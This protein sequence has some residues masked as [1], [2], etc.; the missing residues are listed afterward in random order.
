[1]TYIDS[2][3]SIVIFGGYAVP[4]Y[5]LGSLLMVFAAARWG[6]FP[7]GGFTSFDFDEM[8]AWEQFVDLLHHA[9][10]PLVCY[11][12]GSFA[13]VTLLM[14]NHLLE[15]LAADYVRTAVAKGV[16][17]KGAVFKHALRNSLIPLATNFGQSFTIFV[18][19][20]FLIETIFD[21]DGLG[22]LGYTSTLD[23]D[24]PIVMGVLLVSS[25]FMLVGNLIGDALVALVDP[26]VRF[27]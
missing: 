19:G 23:R 20:S 7:I 18:T 25:I 24:Y 12:I 5:V 1:M 22:L 4:G 16:S 27:K 3:T 17:F 2:L 10:L 13:F 15:S 11:L 26:R 21:I 6:W 9:A 8:N 14:K